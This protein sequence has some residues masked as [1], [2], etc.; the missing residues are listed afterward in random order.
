MKKSI[1][2]FLFTLVV[3]SSFGQTNSLVGAWN[4][5]DSTNEKSLLFNNDGSIS[6]H[7]GP[8]G[9]VIL[10]KNN[11][12][13]TYTYKSEILRIKW[14]NSE[15]ETNTLKFIDENTLQIVFTDKEKKKVYIFNRIID[16]ASFEK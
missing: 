3:K 6:I 13:G 12:K 7:T 1:I 5:S 4:W 10:S 11:K 2:I 16:E 14:Q 8:K 15:I 9:K